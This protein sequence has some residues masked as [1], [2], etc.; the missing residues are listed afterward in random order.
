M[1]IRIL[2]FQ[3]KHGRRK[4]TIGSSIIRGDWLVKHWPEAKLWTEG[5]YSDVLIF[6]KVYWE[7]MMK[8]YPGIKILDLCDPDWLTGE[9]ELVKISKLVDAITC[10]SEGI[11]KFVKKIVK[12]PCFYIPDRVD[13]DFFDKPKKHVGRA[14]RVVWFGYYHNA[15]EILPM[16]LPSLLRLNLKLLVISNNEFMPT[17]TYGVEIENRKFSWETIKFDLT[18]GDIVINPQPINYNKRFRF[19]SNNKTYIAWSC[20]MPV[21]ENV[22][23]LEKFLDPEERNKEAQARL[24]EVREKHNIKISVEEFKKVIEICKKNRKK[25]L[26]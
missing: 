20:G 12:V 15:K 21:A 10:S 9:L 18:Y 2:T 13:L 5:C 4:G 16:V 7:E 3:R 22:E 24:K 25:K 11:Y 17:N 14:E 1:E 8:A 26:K 23:D 6:Q 19:K